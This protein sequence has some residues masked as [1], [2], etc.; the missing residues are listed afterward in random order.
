[1]FLKLV[2]EIASERSRRN[3]AADK[4]AARSAF[5]LV[6][7]LLN[8]QGTMHTGTRLEKLKRR[9]TKDG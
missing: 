8:T 2:E 4:R 7:E 6:S 3:R 9:P 5:G 1:M